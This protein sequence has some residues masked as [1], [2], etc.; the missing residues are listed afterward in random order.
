M[1]EPSSLYV[2]AH[3]SKDAYARFLKSRRVGPQVFDDW[4][5][6][7]KDVEL[8]SGQPSA[9]LIDEVAQGL[10]D[11]HGT[12]EEGIQGWCDSDWS[13]AKSVYD[14]KSGLWQFGVLQFSEN[15]YEYLAYLPFLRAVSMFQEHAQGDFLLVF[16]YIW[17][18][19]V[20][21]LCID[22]DPGASRLHTEASPQRMAEA[23]AFLSFLMPT[24]TD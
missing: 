8:A 16:P 20:C 2:R 18:P 15:I 14:E 22:F 13:F 23:S 7:L 3:L 1:S 6:W 21:E 11:D 12:V 17:S 19:D 4:M 9:A 5:V 10:A 24:D